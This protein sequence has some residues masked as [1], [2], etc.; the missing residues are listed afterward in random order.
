MCQEVDSFPLKL[1]GK[2]AIQQTMSKSKKNLRTRIAWGVP[3]LFLL[4]LTIY[5]FYLDYQVTKKFEGQRW[6]LPSK[7]YSAPFVL[8]Q[9]LDI[10]KTRLMSRKTAGQKLRGIFLKRKRDRNF[11]SRICL[12]RS[13]SER[14]SGR[15]H[16]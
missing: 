2:D 9:G 15:S 3:L 6:K 12:P 16:F 11:S 13:P 4:L 1:K 10:E 7:I 14:L 8:S 5:G